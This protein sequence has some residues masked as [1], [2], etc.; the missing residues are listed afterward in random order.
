M[1]TWAL[2][3]ANAVSP[4]LQRITRRDIPTPC[5]MPRSPPPWA[6]PRAQPPRGTA[7]ALAKKTIRQG[8]VQIARRNPW[9]QRQNRL[10][11]RWRGTGQIAQRPPRL[12]TRW[13]KMGPAA[14]ST[15]MSRLW[16]CHLPR[17]AWLHLARR[18]PHV[19]A[20]ALVQPAQRA[21]ALPGREQP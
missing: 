11:G 17:I 16:R 5:P 3:N 1:L 4:L 7:I 10:V 8:N 9:L 18:P 19:R 12:P 15:T 6:P 2:E 14:G 13:S 21:Q 20:A